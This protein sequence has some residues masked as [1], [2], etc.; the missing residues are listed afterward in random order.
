[1]S[2]NS[3]LLSN[4]MSPLI[5]SVE[6][7][8]NYEAFRYKLLSGVGACSKQRRVVKF[9]P[10]FG[11]TNSI[12]LLKYGLCTHIYLKIK[13]RDQHDHSV[14]TDAKMQLGFASILGAIDELTLS[15]HSKILERLDRVAIMKYILE[16]AKSD[17]DNILALTG[18]AGKNIDLNKNTADNVYYVPLP[19]S[20]FGSMDKAKDLLH[21]QQL[22]VNISWASQSDTRF[23]ITQAK[24]PADGWVY[25]QC[26]LVINYLELPSAKLNELW[27]QNYSTNKPTNQLLLTTF[28]ENQKKIT[29][30]ENNADYAIDLTTKGCVVKSYIVVRPDTG[31]HANKF[32]NDFMGVNSITFKCNGQDFYK[33]DTDEYEFERCIQDMSYNALSVSATNRNDYHAIYEINHSVVPEIHAHKKYSQAISFKNL[34]SPQY[35]INMNNA[36]D[37]TVTSAI[38]EVIH[39]QLNLVAFSKQ[40]G[41]CESILSI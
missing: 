2:S 7:K 36:S 12:N 28:K 9:Q 4:S 37:D 13:I 35:V 17:Q 27:N 26:D 30:S 39:V 16:K 18:Y 6:V 31:T 22:T 29:I 41:S 14:G 10:A 33:A 25:Q 8:S 1:M 34:S 21:L 15:S 38:V 23:L 11:A 24:T 19:F 3:A 20:F 40:D 32:R 5:N